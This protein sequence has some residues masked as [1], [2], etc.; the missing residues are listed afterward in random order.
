V[1]AVDAR[2]KWHPVTFRLEA[3]GPVAPRLTEHFSSLADAYDAVLADVWGVVHNGHAA[4]PEACEALMRFRGRGGTVMLIS[5]APRP[6]VGVIR[7]LDKLDVP[8]GAFDDITTSG[9]VTRCF[10]AGRRGSTAFHL[11]PERDHGIFQGLDVA[12]GSVEAADFVVCTGLFDDDVETPDDYRD[13]LGRLRERRLL[14]VCANPDLVVE[15]GDRLVY[16]AGAIA[17]LY[18]ELGGEV[19][20]AGKPHPAIYEQALGRIA[21]A[22]GQAPLL[23]RVLAIGD[24]VRTDLA[25]ATGIGID[26]LFVTAGI[27]AEEL[28]DRDTPD[29]D[30]LGRMFAAA[31]LSPTAVTRRLVW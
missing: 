5:N 6:G 23:T 19:H 22:R 20:F 26:S 28:G 12:R 9:D 1:T 3:E 31:G 4:F 11:G 2:S 7:L 25:G 27:H 14:M 15:R 16:C 10:L 18:A 21:A 29:L 17:E 30:A 8:R 13:L 24:S